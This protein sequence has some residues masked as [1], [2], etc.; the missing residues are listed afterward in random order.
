MSQSFLSS[1]RDLCSEAAVM[2]DA[3]LPSLELE[4]DSARHCQVIL[5]FSCVE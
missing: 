4:L 5:T 3:L 2:I 1:T